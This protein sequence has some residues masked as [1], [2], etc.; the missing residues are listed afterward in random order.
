MDAA[1]KMEAVRY[2]AA[3]T[4]SVCLMVNELLMNAMK[5]GAPDA[6]GRLKVRVACARK[7][8]RLVVSVWNSGNPI[9]SDFDPTRQQTTGVRLVYDMSVGHYG[10]AFGLRAHEG[11]T[12]AELA[13][14][15]ARLLEEA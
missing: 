14:D 1:C 7:H 8:G 3:A 15:E 5:Y 10:G 11:G 2:P 6:S 4:T 13:I 12:L 9:A